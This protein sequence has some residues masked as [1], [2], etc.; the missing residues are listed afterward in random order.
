MLC[1]NSDDVAHR[2]VG[3][4]EIPSPVVYPCRQLPVSQKGVAPDSPLLHC[5]APDVEWVDEDVAVADVAVDI[6][7]CV[8]FL[9]GWR[10]IQGKFAHTNEAQ[11]SPK[12]HW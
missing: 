12:T 7:E 11:N 1:K 4:S 5:F 6:S 3:L 2:T 8:R 9:V 10:T